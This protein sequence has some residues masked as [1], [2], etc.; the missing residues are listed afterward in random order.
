SLS[1]VEFFQLFPD[2]DKFRV[3]TAARMSATFPYF[4]PAVDLPTGPRRRVVDAGYYDNYGVDVAA[5]W[6]YAHRRWL[7]GNTSGVVLI[8]LRDSTSER[9]RLFP[10]EQP[11]LWDYSRS[12]EW[13]TGPLVGAGSAME[14]GMSFRN[15]EM[16]QV[17]DDFF[18]AG[19]GGKQFTT[20]VF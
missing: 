12:V 1:A 8:Q 5:S 15:D 6:I 3:S 11:K 17:L 20:V 4:S 14:A 2:A 13:L 10:D 16:V 18:N 7:R 9:A 19:G